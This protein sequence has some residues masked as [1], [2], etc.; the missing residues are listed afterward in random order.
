MARR[1]DP[2]RLYI[3]QRMALSAR[4][5][6]D[7]RL[8]EATAELRITAWES[9]ARQRHLDARKPEWWDPAWDWIAEPR[10]R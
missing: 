5:V 4:L 3:A 1:P 7:A 8:S 9:E 6:A 2:E 10:G